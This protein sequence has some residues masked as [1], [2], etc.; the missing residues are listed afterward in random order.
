MDKGNTGPVRKRSKGRNSAYPL[1]P[2][3]H[4]QALT[5]EILSGLKRSAETVS[6]DDDSM[7][8]IDAYWRMANKELDEMGVDP[9]EDISS[10]ERMHHAV[11]VST[12]SLS[13]RPKT[14]GPRKSFDEEFEKDISNVNLCGFSDSDET[15][16]TTIHELSSLPQ[17]NPPPPPAPAPAPTP[18]VRRAAAIAATS[19]KPTPK[20]SRPRKQSVPVFAFSLQSSGQPKPEPKPE[21]R[22]KPHHYPKHYPKHQGVAIIE[23]TKSIDNGSIVSSEGCA[24]AKITVKPKKRQKLSKMQTYYILKGSLVIDYFPDLEKNPLFS[25]VYRKS[26]YSG[27]IIKSTGVFS[28]KASLYVYNPGMYDAQLLCWSHTS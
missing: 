6:I 18:K 9:Y 1:K 11:P 16:T 20:T 3:T 28:A 15:Q 10:L 2:T 24:L 27:K 13:P 17:S 21:P 23:E 7:E 25:Y 4:A 14:V 8:N 22:H 26:S 12:P 5:Q 19:Q